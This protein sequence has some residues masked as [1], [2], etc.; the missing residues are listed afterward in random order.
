MADRESLYASSLYDAAREENAEDAV[1]DALTEIC[2]IAKAEPEYL[3]L[4]DSPEISL[5]EKEEL[6][7]EAFSGRIH[8]YALN[9]MK[10]L[11]KKRLAS[12]FQGCFSEYEKRY[13]A[14]RNIEKAH[15]ATAVEL[16]EAKKAEIVSRLEKSLGKKIIA[17]FEVDPK[18]IGGILIETDK[19]SLDAS[20]KTRLDDMKRHITKN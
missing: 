16:T 7:D 20:V 5:A 19:M 12:I 4:L 2:D 14:E 17:E 3:K 13:F 15:I 18:L 8:L 6:L 10:L 11:S 1:Y 9:F